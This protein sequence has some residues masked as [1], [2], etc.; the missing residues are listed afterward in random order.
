MRRGGTQ[1]KKRSFILFSLF[2][3]P[4]TRTEC[5]RERRWWWN[6]F[7]SILCGGSLSGRETNNLLP[8]KTQGEEAL[9][10][11]WRVGRKTLVPTHVPSGAAAET[12]CCSA[13]EQKSNP[14][15]NSPPDPPPPSP[16]ENTSKYRHSC[17]PPFNRFHLIRLRPIT[18]FA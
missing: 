14:V 17:P 1:N 7:F 11:K 8:A 12:C 13:M 16:S 15:N 2:F 6:A 9:N 4:V 18:D 5:R 10:T 3:I